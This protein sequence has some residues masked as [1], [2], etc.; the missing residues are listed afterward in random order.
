[1]THR[2]VIKSMHFY[3]IKLHDRMH[4][5]RDRPSVMARGRWSTETSVKRYGKMGKV[6]QLLVKMPADALDYCERSAR[7]LEAVLLGGMRAEAAPFRP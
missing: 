3:A 7:T 5:H 6:Q 4:R 2:S 1:M